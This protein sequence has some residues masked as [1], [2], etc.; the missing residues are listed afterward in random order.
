MNQHGNILKINPKVLL[1]IY[2]VMPLSLAFIAVDK[3]LLSGSIGKSLPLDPRVFVWFILIFMVPHILA[4]FFSFAEREYF[5]FYKSK[6]LRGAQLAVVLGLFIP[7]LLG[8]TVIPIVIFA[9]YTMAHVFMQQSGISKSLMRNVAS[10]HRYWQYLGISIATMLYIYLLVPTAGF[11]DTIDTSFPIKTLL[12]ATIIVYTI[13]ALQIVRQS[14]TQ[15]GKTYFIGSHMI[16]IMGVFYVATG[17]PMLA[18]IVPRVMHDLTAY[19]YYITHDN[20]RFRQEQ[21]NVIYKSTSRFRL[22]IFLANPIISIALAYAIV[23]L[24]STAVLSVLTCVFFLHYYT[25]SFIWKN[26]TLHRMQI[27]YTP[28]K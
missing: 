21:A 18:L 8:A 16:P 1:L 3:T 7:A 14:K 28:Y 5:N 23:Q 4:S 9:T 24:N 17:Y 19:T 13:L 10:N 6:M 20:N 22:P 11:R 25:E 26:D 12:T 2:A 27:G 15:L